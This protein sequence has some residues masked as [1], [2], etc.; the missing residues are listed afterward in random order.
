LGALDGKVAIVTGAG[1]GIGA[2]T[3]RLFAKEGA[4]VVLASRSRDQLNEVVAQIEAEIGPGQALTIPTDIS[5]EGQVQALFRQTLEKFGPAEILINNAGAVEIG[6]F[7]DMELATWESVMA[8]NIRG[9][10]LCS[11]EAFRQMSQAGKGG[12][13]VNLSSLSGVRGPEKFPGMSAYVVSKYGVLGFTEILAVEGK[14]YRIRVNCVSPGAVDTAMLK[15][16]APF[17]KTETTPA[18]VALTILYLADDKQSH[19]I[20]GANIEIFS[21]A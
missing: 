8:V 6:P 5:D 19:H 3:A 15:K 18:D 12:A 4:K 17:L 11:R 1:R 21:N 16:A 13:I 9:T 20:T 2:A 14:P 10:F 7:K